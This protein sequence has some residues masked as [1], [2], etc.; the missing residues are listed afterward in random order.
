[1]IATPDSFFLFL[2]AE[3]AKDTITETRHKGY[4][5]KVEYEAVSDIEMDKKQQSLSSVVI[6]SVRRKT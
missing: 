4:R 5:I 2:D 1:M 3:I 6:N